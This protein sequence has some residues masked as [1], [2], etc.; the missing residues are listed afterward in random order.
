MNC[1]APPALKA[2]IASI[3]GVKKHPV[4]NRYWIKYCGDC[5]QLE[6]VSLHT[7]RCCGSTNFIDL[8]TE[9]VLQF[10]GWELV[11]TSCHMATTGLGK[12]PCAGCGHNE[13]RI[14]R[15]SYSIKTG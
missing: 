5:G 10:S 7:C 15:P 8:D 4:H 11:C 12:D 14:V 2:T 6:L 13:F 1:I 9:V 3:L